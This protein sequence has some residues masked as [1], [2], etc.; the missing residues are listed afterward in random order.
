M[1]E[2]YGTIRVP[3]STFEEA[4]ERKN[5][6]GQTW[7]EYLLDENRGRADPESVA[8]SLAVELDIDADNAK[9]EINDL[10]DIVKATKEEVESL[11]SKISVSLD[12]SERT[13]IAREVA[14]ELR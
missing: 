12:A 6:A 14:E 1:A 3:E 11:E 9:G 5:E 4:K 2:D 10:Q 7:A 8:S 13:Q